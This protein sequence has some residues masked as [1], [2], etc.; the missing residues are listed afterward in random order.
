M[1]SAIKKTFQ[2]KGRSS[3]CYAEKRGLS[4][5]TAKKQNSM[6]NLYSNDDLTKKKKC[7]EELEPFEGKK[8]SGSGISPQNK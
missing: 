6:L 8:F 5:Q 7:R 2:Q 3:I 1:E 4:K